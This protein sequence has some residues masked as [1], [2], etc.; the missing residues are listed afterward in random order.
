MPMKAVSSALNVSTFVSLH[1]Y[2]YRNVYELAPAVDV[3]RTL[4]EF[5]G[6]EVRF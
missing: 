5:E 3:R 1:A 6:D 4:L 2:G